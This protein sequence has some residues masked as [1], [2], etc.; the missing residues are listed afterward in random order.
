[1]PTLTTSSSTEPECTLSRREMLSSLSVLAAV[2]ISGTSI[3]LR[4]T[5]DFT[6][7]SEQIRR[8]T[9]FEIRSQKQLQ[10]TNDVILYV[11]DPHH[12]HPDIHRS[13]VDNIKKLQGIFPFQLLGQ[14]GETKNFSEE[15]QRKF[16]SKMR[17]VFVDDGR[18]IN[19]TDDYIAA[20]PTIAILNELKMDGGYKVIGL[21]KDLPTLF[22]LYLVKDM[23]SHFLSFLRHIRAE[24]RALVMKGG[25]F[26]LDVYRVIKAQEVLKERFP[27]IPLFRPSTFVQQQTGSKREN[28]RWATLRSAQAC[29]TYIQRL[30]NWS[31]RIVHTERNYVVADAMVEAL[32]NYSSPRRGVVLF[33]EGH[34]LSIHEV[35]PLQDIFESR[36]FSY[37]VLALPERK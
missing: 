13:L 2:P 14:E 11:V 17:G 9:Q 19:P 34:S 24:G 26:P 7:L 31:D 6:E 36:G 37:M 20:N 28:T 22:D 4:Q 10:S 18:L 25:K 21:E 35:P 15:D 3:S 16:D 32:R 30:N 1:M 12:E 23:S 29:L 33:G 27:E 8:H 5:Q